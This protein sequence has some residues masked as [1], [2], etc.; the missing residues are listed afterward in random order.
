M[1]SFLQSNT[2]FYLKDILSSTAIAWSTFRISWDLELWNSIETGWVQTF[3]VLKTWTQIERFLLTITW[4]VATIVKRG[5]Q[6]DGITANSLLQKTWND[7]TIGYITTKPDDF[8]ASGKLDTNG[9]LRTGLTANALMVTTA[10]GIE[11]SSPISTDWAFISTD[12]ILKRTAWWVWTKTPYS[13]LSWALSGSNN[14]S[15]VS[16]EALSQWDFVYKEDLISIFLLT[17][18]MSKVTNQVMWD[19]TAR[20]KISAKIIWNWVS[21]TIMKLSLSKTAAPADNLVV[22][23][24][25][26]SAWV[27]SGTLAHANATAN[28]TWTWL[29]TSYVDTTIT[30]WWAF[31]LTDWVVYHIVIQR[32]AG[33]DPTNYYNIAH[34]A[35]NVRWF[36]TNINTGASYGSAITTKII[37]ATIT[38]A[39]NSMVCKTS[40]SFV[41]Q[42]YF[43][44]IVNQAYAVWTIASVQKYWITRALTGLSVLTGYML[45]NTAWAI[46]T[47]AWTIARSIWQSDSRTDALVIFPQENNPSFSESNQAVYTTFYSGTSWLWKADFAW[48]LFVT[49]TPGWGNAQLFKNSTAIRNLVWFWSP[50]TDTVQVIPWDVLFA[51]ATTSIAIQILTKHQANWHQIAS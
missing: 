26:D 38:S 10:G 14:I 27:P 4:G 8:I 15:I 44:W 31:T 43:L 18:W 1:S 25:T 28:I 29:T 34:I 12:E 30:F 19:A 7:G 24:E 5:I 32:S 47:T 45:S 23:I 46:S 33:V 51:A 37:Y 41:E 17:T 20:T 40:A 21:M 39:Y 16:W 9:G 49:L 6:Q 13:V 11:Q 50:V 3:V 22:R 36:T 48:T 2:K 35:Q 42:S